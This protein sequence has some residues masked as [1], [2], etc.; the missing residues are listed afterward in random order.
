MSLFANNRVFL[1]V[2]NQYIIDIIEVNIVAIHICQTKQE[3]GINKHYGE[4]NVAEK[5][6][7]T[8]CSQRKYFGII[9][10]RDL[11]LASD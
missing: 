7:N 6:F 4:I 5:G 3:E 8:Y 11:I 9:T 2:I 1:A 10:E